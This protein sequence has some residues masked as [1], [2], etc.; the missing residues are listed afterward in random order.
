MMMSFREWSRAPTL[1]PWACM[2]VRVL[3]TDA[4]LSRLGKEVRTVKEGAER[5]YEG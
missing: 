1:D 5:G 4:Y 2:M 3:Q